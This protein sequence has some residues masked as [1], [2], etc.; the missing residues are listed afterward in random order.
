MSKSREEMTLEELR[1]ASIA[2][3][4]GENPVERSKDCLDIT[5]STEQILRKQ[6]NSIRRI[7]ISYYN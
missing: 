6:V 5:D 2:D 4:S 3:N 1:K 7:P